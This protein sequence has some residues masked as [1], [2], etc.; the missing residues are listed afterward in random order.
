[1]NGGTGVLPSKVY[2]S[3][4]LLTMLICET[5]GWV[6]TQDSRVLPFRKIAYAANM[7]DLLSN[8]RT[9]TPLGALD[10]TV[11]S[12]PKIALRGLCLLKFGATGYASA[13][14]YA[15]DHGG[16]ADWPSPA[17]LLTTIGSLAQE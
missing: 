9:V 15:I 7:A 2:I 10:T 1:M 12:S 16:P 8:V 3:E 14:R 13:N 11:P 6:L 4:R 5:V 17:E